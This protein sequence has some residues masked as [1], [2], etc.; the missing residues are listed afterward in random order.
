[1]SLKMVIV[2][3][4]DDVVP[5]DERQLLF[6]QQQWNDTN[7][8][9]EVCYSPRLQY[10]GSVYDSGSCQ[11]DVQG[12]DWVMNEGTMTDEIQKL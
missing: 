4:F 3:G 9:C 6:A 10:T 2:G 8:F 12:Q 1:M 7:D 5:T 11:C